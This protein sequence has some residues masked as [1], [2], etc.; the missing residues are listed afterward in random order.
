MA[1]LVDFR[2]R[3]RVDTTTRAQP[4]PK[5]RYGFAGALVEGGAGVSDCFSQPT[6]IKDTATV[7]SAS[8][9]IICFALFPVAPLCPG[10]I[11]LN[12]RNLLKGRRLPST[13][14]ES[15]FLLSDKFAPRSRGSKARGWQR[16]S[17]QA[18]GHFATVASQGP[19]LISTACHTLNLRE[20]QMPQLQAAPF[21]LTF[22]GGIA[23][24]AITP[25]TPV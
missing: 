14:L 24:I 23:A 7:S 6:S 3:Q 10:Q 1:G 4:F 5:H 21:L 17:A 12:V 16:G 25:A 2:V 22:P 18:I 15:C 13:N 8:S 11:G 20:P 19:A 9:L